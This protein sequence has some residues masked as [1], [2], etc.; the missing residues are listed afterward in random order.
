MMVHLSQSKKPLWG[1]GEKFWTLFNNTA[2][3]EFSFSLVLLESAHSGWVF[4]RHGVKH[5]I[6]T[7]RWNLSHNQYLINPPL[8]DKNSFLSHTQFLKMNSTQ[9]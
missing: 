8:P 2:F 9:K 5:Y 6:E 1:I 3:N 4:D 7:G